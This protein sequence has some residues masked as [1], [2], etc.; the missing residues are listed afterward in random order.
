MA[1]K[2][3]STPAPIT[4]SLTFKKE[5]PGTFV[6]EEAKPADGTRQVIGTLYVS[7]IAMPTQA[8]GIT[9]TVTPVA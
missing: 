1:A 4:V 6:F 2:N 5:T 9:V 3:T 7:K 8:A